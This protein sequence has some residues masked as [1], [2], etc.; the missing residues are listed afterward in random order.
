MVTLSWLHRARRAAHHTSAGFSL[1]ELMIVLVIAAVLMSAGAPA[2]GSFLRNN[3]L[4]AGALDLLQSIQFARSEAVKRK[5]EVVLCR[6]ADPR[7]ATPSCGGSA[8]TWTT[9]W[10]VFASGDTNNTYESA[11]DELLR[12]GL[13]RS[14]DVAIR[15][16]STSNQNLEFSADGTTDEGGSTARFAIC[17]DRGGAFGYQID[18]PGVG[19]PKRMKGSTSSQINCTSPA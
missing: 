12:V 6:S 1:V 17:D 2:M 16:N 3:R 7:A 14:A 15:T 9:G 5:V 10:L 18:V 4:Q 19:R 13:P 11:N 8:N